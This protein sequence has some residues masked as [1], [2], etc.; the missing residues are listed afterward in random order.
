[1]GHVAR[2]TAPHG[3]RPPAPAPARQ[4]AP[5]RIELVLHMG[6]LAGPPVEVGVTM[7]VLSISSVSE[8]LMVLAPVLAPLAPHPQQPQTRGCEHVAL[9][10]LFAFVLFPSDLVDDW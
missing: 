10:D 2:G 4:A 9:M 6:L 3:R 8:V 7:Y 1:M 5:R